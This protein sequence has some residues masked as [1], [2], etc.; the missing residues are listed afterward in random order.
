MKISIVMPAYNE[1]KRIGKTLESYLDFFKELHKRE[2]LDY[3]ILIVINGTKDK[4]EEII[5]N[6]QKKDRNLKYLNFERGGK[7][8]AITEGFK[9]SLEDN[10]DIIGFVDADLATSPEEFWKLIKNINSYD[11]VIADRYARG[12]KISPAFSFRRLIVS[13]VFNLI[14]RFLFGLSHGD[15]QCGA[16]VFKAS[17]LNKVI[18]DIS[19]TQWAWDIDLL[20]SCKKRNLRIKS[21][22]TVWIEAE[23][24]KLDINKT[25]IQMF[26]AV[27]Q[28][29]ILKSQFRKSLRIISPLISRF[30]NFVKSL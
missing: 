7:G 20:Y 2:K 12:A 21:V 11:G 6:Y 1:E 8:F 22:P 29:R 24:S 17:S 19:M 15:T 13:R 25:S 9:H 4:T 30:Y 28:L 23:G 18:K 26:F 10:F 27:I 16:K 14:V 3:Q 5:K